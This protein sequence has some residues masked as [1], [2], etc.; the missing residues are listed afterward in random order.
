M[1][2]FQDVLLEEKNHIGLLTFNRPQSL[3]AISRGLIGGM[4][5]A[6]EYIDQ[7]PDIR[8][9]I[10]TGS[11]EKAFCA[12]LD[13]KK[14]V[15]PGESILDGWNVRTMHDAIEKCRNAFTMYEKLPVPIIAAIHGYC[16][17][18]GV[19]IAVCCDIRLAADNSIFAMPETKLG[20]VPDMG[21]S[22]RLPRIVGPGMAKE[23]IFTGRRIDANE[24]LR[25]GLV[26]HVYPRDQ[27]M[28]EAWKM[29]EEIAAVTPAVTQGAKSVINF[30]MSSP[31][32]ATLDYETATSL[33]AT[34]FGQLT[35]PN[36]KK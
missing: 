27:L 28:A 19:E 7:H 36:D 22:S 26:Q 3:N 20:I 2:S 6:A 24:A 11:G 16:L 4:K 8:V 17:G 30:S 1:P 9:I 33:Y 35:N 14:V 29:A 15:I 5:E 10:M 32:D 13:L 18:G 31:L 25:I 34:Q 23:L 21:G 12:G